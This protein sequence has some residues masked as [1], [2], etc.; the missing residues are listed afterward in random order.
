MPFQDVVFG[1]V[2]DNV[3]RRIGLYGGIF[4]SELEVD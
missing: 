1:W 4:A 2:G 3:G